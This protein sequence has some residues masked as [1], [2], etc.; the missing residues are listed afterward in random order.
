MIEHHDSFSRRSPMAERVER[1]K[2]GRRMQPSAFGF[3]IPKKGRI[4]IILLLF[5]CVVG[6]RF[7]LHKQP[8]HA[9]IVKQGRRQDSPLVRSTAPLPVQPPPQAPA[10]AITR[11]PTPP[12]NEIKEPTQEQHAALPEKSP[13]RSFFERLG[14]FSK[15]EIPKHDFSASDLTALLKKHPCSPGTVRDTIFADNKRYVV[16]YSI[17]T[18]VQHTGQSLMNQYHP[19]YGALVA[20]E[21]RTG[22]VLALVSYNRPTEPQLGNDLFVKSIFPAASVFKTVTAA[23]AIEK[24]GLNPDSKMQLTGRRYTLYKF[25]LKQD[26]ASSEPVSLEEAYAFSMNP[27]FARIGVYIIGV[28]GIKE[29]IDKFGFNSRIPFELDNEDPHADINPGDSLMVI[30]EIASGFNQKTKMSP[31]FGAMLASS[32]PENG[33]MP[34]PFFVDSITFGGGDSCALYRGRPRT[35]RT[36][37]KASTASYIKSMMSRVAQFGT[38]RS[39]FKY[40]RHSANFDDIDYGGKTG[41][42]DEDKLGKIDWF[43]GFACHPADPRQ[44]IAVGVVTVHDQYWTVHSSFIAAEIFR[45][46]IKREQA[47][48]KI[49]KA[50]KPATIK[51]VG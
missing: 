40:I 12:K 41:T 27:V 21:C 36:P 39:S 37:M 50:E 32:V 31:L 1:A 29:Y 6:T 46:Y 4:R 22:R 42:V 3:R 18:C 49:R 7:L 28:P 15:P 19:K 35:W 33:K 20:M 2:S 51:P 25:Q 17:D 45:K 48:E 9:T 34:V 23:A 43:I 8:P 14:I 10:P 24:A 26:L 44:R 5:F 16:H 13:H 11:E 47:E 38:A 30:A